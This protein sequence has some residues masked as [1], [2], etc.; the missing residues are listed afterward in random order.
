MWAT[1]GVCGIVRP[2]KLLNECASPYIIFKKN[3]KDFMI[4]IA[5]LVSSN[6]EIDALPSYDLL[7]YI[8]IKLQ[9]HYGPKQ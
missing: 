9:W 6:K 4:E 1:C 3:Y 8:D 7:S 2:T 5:N